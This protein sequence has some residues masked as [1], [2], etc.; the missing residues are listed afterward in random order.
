MEG[1][2]QAAGK[3]DFESGACRQAVTRVDASPGLR[4]GGAGVCLSTCERAPGRA[5]LRPE[6]VSNQENQ[7]AGSSS[8]FLPRPHCLRLLPRTV[9][10]C[11]SRRLSSYSTGEPACGPLHYGSEP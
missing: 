8:S 7:D 2:K 9:P 1:R 10:T 5:W 6:R 4:A 11:P 3:S